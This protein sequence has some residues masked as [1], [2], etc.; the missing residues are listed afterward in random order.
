M[1]DLLEIGSRL[2]WPTD[3]EQ[4]SL[5]DLGERKTWGEEQHH[6]AIASCAE[7]WSR[8]GVGPNNPQASKEMS[9]SDAR[10][11]LQR[12]IETPPTSP[13][14]GVAK[15]P[16]FLA[17]LTSSSPKTLANRFKEGFQSHRCDHRWLLYL[18][19]CLQT[20]TLPQGFLY[21]RRSIHQLNEALDV[22]DGHIQIGQPDTADAMLLLS[23]ISHWQRR[24]PTQEVRANR[25]NEK[26]RGATPKPV[27]RLSGTLLADGRFQP[28]LDFALKSRSRP[29]LCLLFELA[30]TEAFLASHSP[31]LA[32]NKAD[33]S[34]STREGWL[35]A[36]KAQT[37]KPDVRDLMGDEADFYHYRAQAMDFYNDPKNIYPAPPETIRE[38]PYIASL[39]A[40]NTLYQARNGQIDGERCPD[41]AKNTLEHLLDCEDWEEK[42]CNPH[43]SK[44]R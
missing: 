37:S 5:F 6:S 8:W 13:A 24:R 7:W 11:I 4:E 38:H 40:L 32:R 33:P 15:D 41:K 25:K 34:N 22:C 44:A 20:P 16:H 17:S 36:I 2:V 26:T 21:H 28:N 31:R 9:L 19:R 35:E 10:E 3:S 18:A 27:A 29:L 30:L 1:H 43:R 39:V 12:V 42:P 14:A 23:L